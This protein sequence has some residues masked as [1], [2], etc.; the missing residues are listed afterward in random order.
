MLESIP[1]SC[2]LSGIKTSERVMANCPR[3][4]PFL[5]CFTLNSEK[6]RHVMFGLLMV[7]VLVLMTVAS[8]FAV[9]A[10]VKAKSRRK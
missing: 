8:P 2:N 9:A 5:S 3:S 4:A 1:L 6:A 10:T 7:L